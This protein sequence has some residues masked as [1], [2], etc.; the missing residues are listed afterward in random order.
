M[1]E[2]QLLYISFDFQMKYDEGV[3]MGDLRCDWTYDTYKHMGFTVSTS[4]IYLSG[5]TTIAQ[6]DRDEKW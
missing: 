6:I 3:I 5:A 4:H 2:R 1:M